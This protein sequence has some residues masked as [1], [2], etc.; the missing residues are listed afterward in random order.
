MEDGKYRNQI[1]QLESLS[2]LRYENIFKMYQTSDGRYFYNILKK[3]SFPTN[4][5]ENIFY[6]ITVNERVPWTTISY[7]AYGTIELWW[8]I[9]L[10]NNLTNPV[11]V[12]RGTIKILKMDYVRP[13][14]SEIQSQL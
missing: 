14:I 4:L 1:P 6:T 10:V 7:N 2:D 8:L 5:S 12:P 3:V 11:S 13:V 9:M